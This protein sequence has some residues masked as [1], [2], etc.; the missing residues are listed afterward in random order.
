M[1]LDTGLERIMR[2]LVAYVRPQPFIAKTAVLGREKWKSRFVGIEQARR[3]GSPEQHQ[4][5]QG[6][7]VE[8]VVPAKRFG[9]V[10]QLLSLVLTG[11]LLIEAVRNFEVTAVR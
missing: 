10:A 2:E 1:C 11:E 8:D 4:V 3:R 5:T 9:I 6:R 7:V